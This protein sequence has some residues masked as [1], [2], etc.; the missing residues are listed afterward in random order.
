MI[1]QIAA[2][3]DVATVDAMRRALD[4][5]TLWEDGAATA[6]GRARAAKTN[7]QAR[8]L[9]TTRGVIDKAREALL[10]HEIVR[11]AAV[12][13]RI[14]RIML[15]RYDAGMRYGDH[16]DAPF[17]DG[18]RSDVSFTLFLSDPSSYDGG[19]LVID[20]AGAE[21]RVRGEA[22]SVVLYPSTAVHRVEEVTRGSRLAVVGWF[23]SRLRSAEMRSMHF[24]IARI[25]ADVGALGGPTGL[26]DRIAN[27]KNNFLRAHGD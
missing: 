7:L 27:L 16:V 17:I 12:P 26:L 22:G 21:D 25:E 15:N 18:E 6:L 19:E 1:L 24:E 14:A 11:N 5:S 10:S 4:D 8:D 13:A 9:P 23:R 3:L 2:V 20:S